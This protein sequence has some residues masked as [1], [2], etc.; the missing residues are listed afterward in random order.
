[1]SAG[2]LASD[3]VNRDTDGDGLSDYDELYVYG[4]SPYL[5]DTDG[6]GIP[7]G[8]EVRNGTD[9]NCPQG[10]NCNIGGQPVVTTPEPLVT[11][12]PTQPTVADLRQA[13]RNSGVAAETIDA[14][15]DEQLLAAY[16]EAQA[17]VLQN[18]GGGA[19]AGGSAGAGVGAINTNATPEQIRDLLRTN[20]VSDEELNKLSDAEL[21]SLYQQS[22]REIEN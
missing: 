6:D 15:T 8:E 13:L 19:N 11:P 2:N 3:L 9:P 12:P 5:A 1:M 14:L 17:S 18:T 16:Q 7:D 10:Q 21:V 22:L 20:G 4:T